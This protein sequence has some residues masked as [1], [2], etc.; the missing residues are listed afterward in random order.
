MRIIEFECYTPEIAFVLKAIMTFQLNQWSRLSYLVTD[1]EYQTDMFDESIWKVHTQNENLYWANY[2]E[3]FSNLGFSGQ[4]IA[5]QLLEP[6][7]FTGVLLQRQ[8]LPSYAPET[9]LELKN[10][11]DLV[12][13]GYMV[14]PDAG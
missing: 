11:E 14:E 2:D 8:L 7:V 12:A 13:E 9:V 5:T 6:G 1:E 10:I 3:I 4:Q